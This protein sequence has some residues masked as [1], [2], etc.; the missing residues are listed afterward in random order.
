MI[1]GRRTMGQS[2]AAEQLQVSSC[3]FQVAAVDLKN[4]R[5]TIFGLGRHGGGVAAARYC[6]LAGAAV[7]VTDL[8]DEQTLAESLT[9]LKD[10]GIAKHALGGHQ[11]EDFRSTDIVVVNPAVKPGN[12][13]VQIARQGGARIASETE[14][15]LDA[16]P[17]TVIGVTG[18]VG[19]STTAAMTA[20]ILQRGGKRAW[21]GGN[22]GHSLL[23]DLAEIRAAD[24]VVLE[25][26][27]FQ[28]HWLSDE[29][30]W[31]DMAV[32]TNCAANHLDWH[33]TWEHYAA[34][35]QR[36]IRRMPAHGFAVLNNYDAQVST[37]RRIC[38]WAARPR[39]LE[40]LPMLRLTGDHNR[41]N[42]ACAARVAKELGVEDAVI[43]QALAEFAGLP[44]RMQFSGDFS[45]RRFYNDS[46][47]TTPAATIAALNT[48]DRSTWLLLGG[49]DKEIELSELANEVARNAK[50]AAVFG[51]VAEKLDD[52]IRNIDPTFPVFR[53]ETMEAALAWCWEQSQE[54]DAILLS[55]ACAS[56]DQFR[57][58]AQRGEVFERLV[59]EISKSN[60]V[61]KGG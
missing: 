51:A 42:A 29:A 21:L 32:V 46:K 5:V 55:P 52:A 18:T 39:R 40:T 44:H 22:I 61:R 6:A 10:V 50:G 36:L 45:G 38:G 58:F 49:A 4:R 15:F 59:R 57:D 20:A 41:I 7:T 16:C 11:E 48:M 14:L 1:A 33:G 3:R 54:G 23:A 47:A 19:K 60:T 17:A 31:P 30:R 37:W 25:M 53:S 12:R 13:F 2:R 34:A 28:L 35:K 26:S 27:S 8:A 43:S 24:F 56:T 9:Q